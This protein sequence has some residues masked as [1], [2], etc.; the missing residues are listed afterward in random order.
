M[1]RIFFYLTVAAMSSLS[2]HEGQAADPSAEGA[3][4]TG[5]QHDGKMKFKHSGKMMRHAPQHPDSERIGGGPGVH[6]QRPSMK[7]GV[8]DK[9]KA[10]QRE[11]GSRDLKQHFKKGQNNANKH[12]GIMHSQQPG[13]QAPHG[14]QQ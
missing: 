8:S 4:F 1:N 6:S 2:I 11:A 5:G 12:P 14:G 13:H 9:R 7:A 3:P 10:F